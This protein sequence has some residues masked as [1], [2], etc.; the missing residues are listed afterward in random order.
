MPIYEYTCNDCHTQFEK[1]VRS[2]TAPI[3]V[4]CPECGGTHVKKGWS[5][6]GA[7]VSGGSVSLS[8]AG[9][10]CAPTGT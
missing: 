4:Q 5:L 3:E 2:I 7:K 1:L 9:G 6:F 10:D 8:S